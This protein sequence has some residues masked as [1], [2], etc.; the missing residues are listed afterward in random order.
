MEDDSESSVGTQTYGTMQSFASEWT[1]C[2]N[3]SFNRFLNVFRS[4][5][6]LHKEMLAILAAVTEVIK[7]NGGTESATEYFCALV[8][9]G[10][11]SLTFKVLI[12]YY[13]CRSQL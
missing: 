11:I 5:S 8:F 13:F 10:L 2:S 6:A 3:M 4:D 7:D 1:E 12:L 9:I